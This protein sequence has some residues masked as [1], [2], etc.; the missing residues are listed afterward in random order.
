MQNHRGNCFAAARRAERS[1]LLFRR[2]NC[3]MTGF[4]RGMRAPPPPGK[5][6]F[7]AANRRKFYDDA[8]SPSPDA[9]A[10]RS[11]RS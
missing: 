8:S 7:I 9:F 1:E 5:F 10:R 4:D 6:D 2:V 11:L 3:L